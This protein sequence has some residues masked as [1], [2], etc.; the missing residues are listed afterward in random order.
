MSA[1]D[2][3]AQT[4]SSLLAH[5]FTHVMSGE[6]HP[7]P[8]CCDDARAMIL[9][10]MDSRNDRVAE[11]I[12]RMKTNA[13]SNVIY[14]ASMR[15]VP[16]APSGNPPGCDSDKPASWDGAG[17]CRCMKCHRCDRHTGNSTQGHYWAH[18][19][20]TGTTRDFHHCCPGACELEAA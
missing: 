14:E 4:N 6:Y 9:D 17:G 19:R 10:R 20:V 2:L 8:A 15:A 13:S 1:L 12:E 11:R 16:P 5:A 3:T 18:C 7:D